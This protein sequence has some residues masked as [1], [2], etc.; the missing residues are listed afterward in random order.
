MNLE[1]LS[2]A[3]LEK[4]LLRGEIMKEKWSEV[5]PGIP[6][7]VYEHDPWMDSPYFLGT[8]GPY[9]V[10]RTAGDVNTVFRWHRLDSN[11]LGEPS[12]EYQLAQTC[13]RVRH[14]TQLIGDSST[15]R[16]AYIKTEE[17]LEEGA[18]N[19]FL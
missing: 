18:Q 1:S 19:Y 2:T 15:M 9:F 5:G 12:F 16:I 13:E 8:M 3:D 10:T 6:H 7:A 4:T 14:V 17:T 11:D